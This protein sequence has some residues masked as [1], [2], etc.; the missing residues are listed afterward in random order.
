M[1]TVRRPMDWFPR[2]LLLLFTVVCLFGAWG[3]WGEVKTVRA[4][5][6]TWHAVS[7]HVVTSRLYRGS[8]VGNRR[9][10]QHSYDG[11]WFEYAY[12][13]PAGRF[14]GSAVHGGYTVEN[15]EARSVARAY[16]VGAWVK[17]YYNP[18]RP[19]EAIAVPSARHGWGRIV[20]LMALAA[21]LF[22]VSFVRFA[23]AQ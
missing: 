18:A 15:A 7:A 4:Q 16:P 21:F 10:S 22:G 8:R 11:L 23:R 12:Q 9:S 3:S 20:G 14:V 2:A 17:A 1:P 6:A 13:T 5:Q 19:S